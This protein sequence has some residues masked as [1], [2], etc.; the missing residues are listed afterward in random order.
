MSK[1]VITVWIQN[2]AGQHQIDL[3]Q[4]QAELE[5]TIDGI[6]T[7]SDMRLEID[8]C[9]AI[10]DDEKDIRDI[11]CL[12]EML[13][14]FSDTEKE[15]YV[16]LLDAADCVGIRHMLGI[17]EHF[18]EFQFVSHIGDASELGTWY[19][20]NENPKLDGILYDN[21][22]FNGVGNQLLREGDGRI[23]DAG[24][25]A[26]YETII[27]RTYDGVKLAS[28]QQDAIKPDCPLIGADGNVFNL[29]GI[30][31]RTLKDNGMQEEAKQMCE[32]VRECGSY[33]EALAVM[34]EYVTPVGEEDMTNDFEMGGIQ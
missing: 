2:E 22:D 3:P 14:S 13:E 32:R 15:Q 34:M 33:D 17:A 7:D 5:S 18:K 1:K 20:D 25:V 6:N 8:D 28:E 23:T 10:L 19:V 30:A 11:N 31:S 9:I 21:L 4:S 26:N 29:M 24:Y 27:N 16:A 12:A